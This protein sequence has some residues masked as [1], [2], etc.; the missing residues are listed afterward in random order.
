MIV[1]IYG[2]YVADAENPSSLGAEDVE[3]RDLEDFDVQSVL[4]ETD[5]VLRVINQY[6]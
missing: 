5:K 6:T 4:S 1:E 3:D 2:Y